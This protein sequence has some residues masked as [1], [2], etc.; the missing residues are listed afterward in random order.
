M[1]LP[2]REAVRAVVTDEGGRLLLVRFGLS[3]GSLW[4]APGGGVEHGESHEEA[5]RRELHEEVGLLDAE[6]GPPIWFRTHIV[7]LSS[8]FSGQ[9]E[10]FYL[11]RV[12][13][14]TGSPAVGRAAT[15]RGPHRLAVVDIGGTQGVDRRSICSEESLCPLRIAP[16]KRTPR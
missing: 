4:A 12:K 2:L 15:R 14:V 8:D 7:P 9:Q 11:V 6:I 1:D 10:T 3:E 16:E 13:E 5:I